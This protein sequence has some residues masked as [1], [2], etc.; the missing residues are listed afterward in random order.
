MTSPTSPRATPSGFTMMKV[1]SSATSLLRSGGGMVGPLQRPSPPGDAQRTPDLTREIERAGDHHRSRRS[2]ASSRAR[3]IAASEALALSRPGTASPHTDLIDRA[4]SSGATGP[5]PSS[6]S[7][8]DRGEQPGSSLPDHRLP[9]LVSHH[10]HAPAPRN[11]GRTPRRASPRV[12]RTPARCGRR[13]S[14]RE[15]DAAPPRAARVR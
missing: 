3:T 9:V 8:D 1:R 11:G 12:R 4:S 15:D 7:G 13:R 10:T 5:G 6:G 14:G 2:P